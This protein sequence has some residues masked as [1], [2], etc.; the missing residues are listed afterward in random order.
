MFT[1]IVTTVG[2]IVKVNPSGDSQ[3]GLRLTIDAGSLD[4][5]RV[6]PGDSIAIQ[7]ACMT[8]VAKEGKRFQVDISRES[9]NLTVGLDRV[10]DVNLEGALRV[11]DP[12]GGHIVSGHVDGLGE[13]VSFEPVG[14]SH[15]LVLH[16]PAEFAQFMAYKGS[17]AVNGA[18]LT[19]NH[20]KDNATGCHIRVNIIPHT[21]AA[22]TLNSLRAGDAVNIEVDTLARYVARMTESA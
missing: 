13:V 8:V 14:E 7:G 16:I 17:V 3:A 2:R 11:G 18:S 1:G 15:E 22:T 12:L 20:V 19:V 21:L 10:G 6:A 4:L 5:T 9:L